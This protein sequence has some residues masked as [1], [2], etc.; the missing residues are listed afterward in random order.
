MFTTKKRVSDLKRSIQDHVTKTKTLTNKISDQETTAVNARTQLVDLNQ[1]Q[2]YL[3]Q[4]KL[5]LVQSFR[6]QEFERKAVSG[7]SV[8]LVRQGCDLCIPCLKRF[9]SK[10]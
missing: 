7:N 1:Q 9:S 8:V 3:E 6:G 5:E 2:G 10:R 4:R